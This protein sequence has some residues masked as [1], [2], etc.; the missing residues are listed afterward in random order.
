MINW[1]GNKRIQVNEWVW[2]CLRQ[3]RANCG[4]GADVQVRH[5]RAD[6]S[7]ASDRKYHNIVVNGGLNY[8]RSLVGNDTGAGGALW[9]NLS[10]NALAPGAADTDLLAT[11]YTAN[12]LQRAVGAY[13][14]GGTGVYTSYKEFTNADA[15]HSVKSVGL[16]YEDGVNKLLAGVA[17]TEALLEVGDKLQITW[18]CTFSSV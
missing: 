17:V 9:I 15:Q 1:I 16:T 4:I 18:T 13:A 14:A 10:S 11:I 3:Y 6:G 8:L 12:G 5:I 7:I 2:K